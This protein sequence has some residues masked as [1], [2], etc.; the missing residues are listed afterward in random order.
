MIEKNGIDLE[1]FLVF[2]QKCYPLFFFYKAPRGPNDFDSAS[3]ANGAR[4]A[5][6]CATCATVASVT[7]TTSGAD[8]VWLG[9]LWR[10]YWTHFFLVLIMHTI[11]GLDKWDLVGFMVNI[12]IVKMCS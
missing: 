12:S 9:L 5:G 6:R 8:S 2:G 11:I 7:S 4:H 3:L 1:F 10:V